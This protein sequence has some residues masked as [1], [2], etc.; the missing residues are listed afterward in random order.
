M[1]FSERLQ[2]PYNYR[3]A[4]V[5]T[6]IMA[7]FSHLDPVFE[8][9]VAIEAANEPISDAS[10]TPGYGDFQKYFVLTVRAVETTLGIPAT[11]FSSQ[12]RAQSFNFTEALR[13]TA[14]SGQFP[15][16]VNQAIDQ[17]VSILPQI[18]PGINEKTADNKSRQL[19]TVYVLLLF[20]RRVV[21]SIKL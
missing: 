20:S 19:T 1:L 8:S 2:T 16:E 5:W 17:A 7:A 21:R 15:N 4:L 3:R 10:K 12:T 14:N 13:R 18:F 9:V 11:R 6:V